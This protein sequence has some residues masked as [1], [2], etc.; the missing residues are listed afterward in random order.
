VEVFLIRH[1]PAESR[2]PVRWPDDDDRPLSRQGLDQTRKAGRGFARLELPIARIVTSPA[3][4]AKRTAELFYD[5]LRVDRPIETWEELS[6]ETSASAV[7]KRLADDGRRSEGMALFGHEP[8]LSE[9]IG[10]AIAGEAVSLV[11]FGRA[12]AAALLFQKSVAPGT[13]QLDWLL[14]RRQLVALDQ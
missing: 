11:H 6:P 1:G 3:V 2:D 10:L 14:T 8:T 5:A 9:V 7:L 13:G 12:G 4:R